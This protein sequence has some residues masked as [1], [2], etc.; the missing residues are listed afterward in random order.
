MPG[1]IAIIVVLII[2]LTVPAI[3]YS[4]VPKVSNHSDDPRIM[5]GCYPRNYGDPEGHSH[6]TAEFLTSEDKAFTIIVPLQAYQDLNVSEV[7]SDLTVSGRDAKA[8]VVETEYGFGLKISG[9]GNVS[10]DAWSD[11]I[12]PSH[13]LSLVAPLPENVTDCDCR[14]SYEEP[15]Y[16]VYSNVTLDTRKNF[17]SIM[18]EDVAEDGGDGLTMDHYTTNSNVTLDFR[19]DASGTHVDGILSEKGGWYTFQGEY[20]GGAF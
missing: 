20:R 4:I 14:Q 19:E 6:Y 5:G 7:M 10:V 11:T 13:R 9:V 15:R 18:G 17:I 8:E 2:S 1:K 12:V 16:M 3:I